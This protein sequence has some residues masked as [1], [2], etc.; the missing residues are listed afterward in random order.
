VRI[1]LV[2]VQFEHRLRLSRV[3]HGQDAR[4]TLANRTSTIYL[5]ALFL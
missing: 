1:Y 4:A 3:I 2:L 5:T